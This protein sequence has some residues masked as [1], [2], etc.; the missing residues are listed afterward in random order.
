MNELSFKSVKVPMNS[1][2][3]VDKY[4]DALPPKVIKSFHNKSVEACREELKAMD[5]HIGILWGKDRCF[6][7]FGNNKPQDEFIFYKLKKLDPNVS[8]VKDAEK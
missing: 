8:Y 4:I 6:Y 7:I 1:K 5:N 3:Y 2:I